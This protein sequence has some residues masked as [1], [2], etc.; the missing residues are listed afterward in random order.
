[1]RRATY[2]DG[3]DTIHIY[4]N[5]THVS[6]VK[7]DRLVYTESL[8]VYVKNI[9]YYICAGG[10]DGGSYRSQDEIAILSD[11]VLVNEMTLEVDPRYDIS[12]VNRI[13]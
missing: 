13:H 7:N 1:M 8:D 4:T 5:E 12:C 9:R 10:V 6:K 11:N 2:Y 3:P